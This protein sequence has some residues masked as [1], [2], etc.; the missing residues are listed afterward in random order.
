[1][2]VYPSNDTSRAVNLDQV[3]I[4]R[5]SEVGNYINFLD[6]NEKDIVSWN[7][8]TGDERNRAYIRLLE[9]INAIKINPNEVL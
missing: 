2:F 5:R 9:K 4:I 7:Y 3:A 6:I 8:S 1:M